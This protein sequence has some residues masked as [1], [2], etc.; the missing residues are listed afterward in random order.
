MAT[1]RT[2]LELKTTGFDKSQGDIKKLTAEVDKLKQ[3]MKDL[4][5]EQKKTSSESKKQAGAFSNLGKTMLSI[6][7]AFVIVKGFQTLNKVISDSVQ[8]T[9][10]FELSLAKVQAVSGATADEL[11][12]L[13]QNAI[14]LGSSSIFTANQVLEL[15]LALAK[16]G[17]TSEEI[18]N[19]SGGIVDLATATGEDLASSADV[20]ASTL[21]GFNLDATETQ[22]VVDVMT[23]SFN[24][25]GLSL[26]NFRQSIKTVAPVAEAANVSIEQTTSLLGVL[27]NRG[28][29]GSLAA[30]GL[31][32][33][34]ADLSDPSSDLAKS[35]GFTITNAN[36]L[37]DALDILQSRN[38][39]LTEAVELV[40]KRTRPAFL[41]LV[42]GS[43]DVKALNEE[44]TSVTGSAKAAAGI[45][46]D[47][48]SADLNKFASA[49]EALIVT[50]EGSD[51]L[52]DL[53]QISTFML[54][55]ATEQ[56]RV[57]ETSDAI[58][59]SYIDL[60]QELDVSK[61]NLETLQSVWDDLNRKVVEN[62]QELIAAKKGLKD[63]ENSFFG[64]GFGV[65][66]AKERLEEAEQVYNAS[67]LALDELEKSIDGVEKALDRNNKK[68]DDGK[69]DLS[70]FNKEVE[71]GAHFL[72]IYI[73]ELR[74]LGKIQNSSS[75][76]LEK[77]DQSLEDF[78]DRLQKTSK[79]QIKA[80]ES[81]DVPDGVSQTY[82][83]FLK[84]R[85][86]RNDEFLDAS[87]EV[88]AATNEL[89]NVLTMNRLV[90]VEQSNQKEL[91]S[92]NRTQDDR[93]ARLRT[94][95]DFEID[96]FKGTEDQKAA[97]AKQKNLELL[98]EEKR[99]NAE[100]DALRKKQLAEENKIARKA[101]IA[102][103]A[104]AVAEIAINLQ[105]ELSAIG[106][107][108]AANPLN[109]VTAGGAGVAQYGTLSA[110]AI[111]SSALQTGAVLAQKFTPK[112]FQDGG[113]LSG[114]SH[115]EGGIPFTVG[116]RGGFEAEGGEAIINKKSTAMFAPLLSAINQAG[117][118]VAFG[119]ASARPF[120][121][122]G[123]IAGS[124]GSA[125][126]L[127]NEML[128]EM[129][130]EAVAN[131]IQEIP[132]INVATDTTTLANR[133]INA[134]RDSII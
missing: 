53:V 58:L 16:L 11:E 48:L 118:G 106:V 132:V 44:L 63:A 21:R 1:N 74:R 47:T 114:A 103:K 31:K 60:D 42:E 62:K 20:A 129:I 6:G 30:T 37:S 116:G 85:K 38:I 64:L 59:S 111:A 65:N 77:M 115:S 10:D 25:S 98:D 55:I 50:L 81:F 18:Q 83:E 120:Y 109:A 101:F 133:V 107:N 52:R 66:K 96:T 124:V 33:V 121:Q 73:N 88:A 46:G 54:R 9:I 71:D 40:D 87:L 108:A 28:I 43:E 15:Q 49:W 89:F 19:A 29:R 97:F 2:I 91:D 90:E 23:K 3:Q 57:A 12:L 131:R 127:N 41:A 35:L 36:G 51:F 104:I 130:G 7:K 119:N 34:I 24:S 92:F 32:N 134:E 75:D 5:S 123:G 95:A 56:G 117:G 80:W 84:E 72:D 68:L 113:I 22:R 69:K 82:E 76:T 67:E 13:K 105:K 86:Q 94:I 78:N 93:L 99:V 26:S 17:F 39:D 126:S 61:E 14:S 45:L 27:A 122:D 102:N 79:E 125:F 112:T 100:R 4:R 70:E 128:S 110:L 8:I